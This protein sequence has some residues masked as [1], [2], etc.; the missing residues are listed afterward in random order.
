MF[1]VISRILLLFLCLQLWGCSGKSVDENDPKALFEDAEESIKGDQYQI[2]IDK[3]RMIRN[4]FP[5]SKYSI[6]A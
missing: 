4:K 2:A 1:K 3:L 5:Y 6:E